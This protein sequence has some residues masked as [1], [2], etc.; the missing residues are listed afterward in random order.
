MSA[1]SETA[2]PL[3]RPISR[4]RAFRRSRLGRG[5]TRSPVLPPGRNHLRLRAVPVP[6]GAALRVH[7]RQRTLLHAAP[8]H[9]EAPDAR[10][11]QG[12]ARSLV[13]PPRPAQLDDRRRLRDAALAGDRLAGRLC[14]R[15]IPLPRPLVRDVPDAVDDDLPADR[16]PRCSLHDD[17]RIPHRRV[18]PL[19]AAVRHPLGADLHVP[20]LHAAVHGLGAD[21]LHEARCRGISKRRRTSTGR[22]RSRSS[23]R[24]SCL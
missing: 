16:D 23:T 6:V 17:Q 21:E 1:V 5:L 4:R 19:P 7:A 24:C 12:G 10:Q 15:T 2:K 14:P 11:L 3:A 22:P 13:L 9:P 18:H 20:H 8:V